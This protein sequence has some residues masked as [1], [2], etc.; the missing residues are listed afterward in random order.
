LGD[1]TLRALLDLGLQQRV[2][3][4]EMALLRPD[5]LL[6]QRRELGEDRGHP[7]CPTALLNRGPLENGTRL[8][9]HRVISVS[10]RL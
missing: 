1:L 4:L 3:I 9:R 7:K 6:G 8:G 2:E 5:S 10:S